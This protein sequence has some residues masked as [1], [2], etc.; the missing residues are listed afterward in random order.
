M[1]VS[2]VSPKMKIEKRV[3][4]KKRQ[5]IDQKAYN[6]R[7]ALTREKLA[8]E[9]Q[10]KLATARIQLQEAI[11]AEYKITMK[12][13]SDQL[14]ELAHSL[15]QQ[16]DLISLQDARIRRQLV[17]GV[18]QKIKLTCLKNN[19]KDLLDMIDNG[20]RVQD[21]GTQTEETQHFQNPAKR[22]FE[23]SSDFWDSDFKEDYKLVIEH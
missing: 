7:V 20:T 16:R 8:L 11:M 17:E 14:A 13:Q 2:I 18:D 23:E 9:K 5:Y 19:V 22:L 6:A 3:V 4:S 10:L 15:N 1:T 12:R 21:A